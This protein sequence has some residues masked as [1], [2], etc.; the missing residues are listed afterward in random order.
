MRASIIGGL[1]A[2]A[3]MMVGCGGTELEA[4]APAELGQ[5][6]AGALNKYCGFRN[7]SATFY[8]DA[9]KTTVVGYGDCTC[10]SILQ[11]T[12]T[13]TDYYTVREY[14]RCAVLP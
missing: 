12:G 1:L 9:T 3:V 8:S 13:Q 6:E 4:E 14:P 5:V 10:G 11:V 2:A 7:Y